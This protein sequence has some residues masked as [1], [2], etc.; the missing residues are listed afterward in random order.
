MRR[1]TIYIWVISIVFSQV[2]FAE[3]PWKLIRKA[4][5]ITIY[6]R[7]VPGTGFSQF[8]ALTKA[9]VNMFSLI[10]L[11]SNADTF[12]EWMFSCKDAVI[13]KKENRQNYLI[14]IISQ[15]PWP[16]MNRDNILDANLVQDPKTGTTTIYLT[17]R[18]DYIEK[19]KNLVRVV[20]S[21]GFVQ[22]K[23]TESGEI[24]IT[25]EFFLDPGGAIPAP[26][27]NLFISDFPFFTLKQM[28]ETAMLPKYRSAKFDF[29]KDFP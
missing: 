24:E 18:S 11:W 1:T 3:E 14:Y 4:E 27:A 13:L 10:E 5:G 8:R 17:G 6:I 21:F 15:V 7:P 16:L 12:K 26:I 9:K 20:R 19:K 23:P 29:L 2:G 28:K 22:F 25:F